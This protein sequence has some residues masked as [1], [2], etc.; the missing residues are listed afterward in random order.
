MSE[1]NFKRGYIPDPDKHLVSSARYLIGLATPPP[2]GT[3]NQ[4]SPPIRNQGGKSQCTG[5]GAMGAFITS[6]NAHSVKLPFPVACPAWAYKIARAVDRDNPNI[7]LTDDGA[8]PNQVVRGSQEFGILALGECSDADA[9]VNREPTIIELEKASRVHAIGWHSIMTHGKDLVLDI[10][11][12]ISLAQIAVPAS[13]DVDQPFEDY[14]GKGI[15]PSAITGQNYGG[16]FFYFTEFQT[17][18]SGSILFRLRNSWSEDWGEKGT[19]W[20]DD[21][22]IMRR[23]TSKFTAS[24]IIQGAG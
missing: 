19:G 22:F 10:M 11:R 9:D 13:S 6:C 5:E 4:F 1:G 17:T 12:A 14:S 8:M 7:P 23:L 3:V 16:H 24:S 21:E 20:V 18:V 15:I 2:K